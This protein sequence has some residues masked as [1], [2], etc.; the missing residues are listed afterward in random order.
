MSSPQPHGYSTCLC[1]PPHAPPIP[2]AI[3]GQSVSRRYSPTCCPQGTPH[4]AVPPD[5][6]IKLL[7]DSQYECLPISAPEGRGW[8]EYIF[9]HCGGRPAQGELLANSNF[10]E[11][12]PY[13]PHPPSCRSSI[14]KCKGFETAMQRMLERE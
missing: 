11:N 8:G 3:R 10:M 9:I 14:W 13:L 2:V 7:A 1:S 4:I 12:L 5:A 6:R